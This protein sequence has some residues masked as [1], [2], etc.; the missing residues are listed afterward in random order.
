LG[1]AMKLMKVEYTFRLNGYLLGTL[2][3][4]CLISLSALG[5]NLLVNPSAE[6]GDLSGWSTSGPGW[7]AGPDPQPSGV[8]GGGRDGC[9]VFFT[10]DDWCTR[11]QTVSLLA[12]GYTATE[13]DAVPKITFSEWFRGFSTHFIP[14]YADKAY[15]HVEL[16]KTENGDPVVSY[17][18]GEFTTSGTWEQK[19][20]TFSGYGAGV[21]YVYWEDGGK[22]AETTSGSTDG[23]VLDEALLTIA[24]SR[25]TPKL[26]VSRT[27][28]DFGA[29]S[30]SGEWSPPQTVTITN[31]GT[32][33]MAVNFCICAGDYVSFALKNAPANDPIVPG[34]SL[35]LSVV[36]S[37]FQL[38]TRSATLRVYSDDPGNPTKSITLRGFGAPVC[39][40]ITRLDDSP[41]SETTVRFKVSFSDGVVGV[42]SSD[43]VIVESG[44]TGSS[45]SGVAQG[46]ADGKDW[47]VTVAFGRGRGT[48]GI[49]LVDNNTIV[50][51]LYEVEYPLGGA[52]SGNG[53]FTGGETY[54]FL[55]AASPDIDSSGAVNA[56]DIQLVINEVLEP[57]SAPPGM[58]TDV[59]GN[60]STGAED[61]QLVTN[62]ALDR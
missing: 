19:T 58:D 29:F 42:D 48:V 16:R 28:I 27:T 52:G 54:Q 26:V 6:T 35:P 38:G 15:L 8:L 14:N 3:M 9:A 46:D 49:N 22:G 37:P 43:F 7:S 1:K 5:Q 45:L 41:T 47:I 60:G 12:L 53:N 10:D 33:A 51:V 34:G 25:A 17:D 18:S 21:R 11:S 55:G 44:V 31:T 40:G 59:D 23:P 24:V 50:A 32:V 30:R 20:G 62:A 4:L 39:T 61:V 13:L 57:G 56:R 36:F 2:L